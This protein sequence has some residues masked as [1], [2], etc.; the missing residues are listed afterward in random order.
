MTNLSLFDIV[1]MEVNQDV[2]DELTLAILHGI[3]LTDFLSNKIVDFKVLRGIRLCMEHGV[4][5]NYIRANLHEGILLPLF[6]VYA[7]NRTLESTG[8]L[9]YFNSATSKL[10]IEESTFASLVGLSLDNIR[11]DSVDFN[12][13]PLSVV[14]VFISAIQQGVDVSDLQV[15]YASHDKDYLEFMVSLRLSGI[16][17]SPFLDGYWSIEQVTAII[18]GRNKI[19]PVDFVENHINENFTTG[20]IECCIKAFDYGCLNLVTSLD[21]DGYPVF[22]EYQMYQITEGAR[23]GLDYMSYADPDLN[24]YQM[25][26]KRASLFQAKDAETKGALSSRLVI[27]KPSRGVY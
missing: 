27:D 13:I 21:S 7:S 12:K 26:L 10:T 24:D 16:D 18:Q 14:E 15:G 23:F 1:E 6:E 11:F 9:V 20:Q 8:L 5:L 2:K 22:N 4:P 25:S 17:I 3:D 19:S